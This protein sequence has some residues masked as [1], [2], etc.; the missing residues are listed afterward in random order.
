MRFVPHFSRLLPPFL[1]RPAVFLAALAQLAVGLAPLAEL[2]DTSNASAHV[3]A[4][5]IAL[6]HAHNE[7]TCI[8]CA[9]QHLMAGAIPGT[10]SEPAVIHTA[11]G[12]LTMS[13]EIPA[14]SLRLTRRSRAPPE[15]DL[16][17]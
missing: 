3:E 7:A 4:Q 14:S 2:R 5:G 9:A 13:R 6:H 12:I 8:A 1:W 17:G 15:T 16:A 11:T 10:R